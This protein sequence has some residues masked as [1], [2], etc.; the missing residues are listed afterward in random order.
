LRGLRVVEPAAG[1]R[2]PGDGA[3]WQLPPELGGPV[4]SG[5]GTGPPPPPPS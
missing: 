3:D 5:N 2:Q 1:S 4:T